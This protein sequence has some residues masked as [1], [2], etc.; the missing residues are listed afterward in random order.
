MYC[1]YSIQIFFLISA[2]NVQALQAKKL[3]ILFVLNRFPA[4]SKSIIVNQMTSLIDAGHNVHIYT[5]KIG[6]LS[7]IDGTVKKYRLFDKK[8]CFFSRPKNLDQ[9]DII[10]V[11]Y[12]NLAEEFVSIKKR[13]SV[14]WKLVVYFRGADITGNK[15]AY[16]EEY[17]MLFE[18]VD[19]CLTVCGYYKYR[20]RKIF[21]CPKEKLRVI[22]STIDCNLFSYY[23]PSLRKEYV[24]LI[25]VGRLIQK[26]GMHYIIRA[27]ANLRE[28]GHRVYL[29]I[30]GEGCYRKTLEKLIKK[31]KLEKF[32]I[33]HGWKNQKVI[34]KY[35]RSSDIFV[36]P[37]ITIANGSQ[38]GI[39]NAL[40]EAM[41]IGRPVIA[42]FHAGTQELVEQGINGFLVPERDVDNLVR[43]ILYLIKWPNL[44]RTMGENGR[45][46]VLKEY[47][48][49]IV[50]K[51]LE[52]VLY[53]LVRT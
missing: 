6:D 1:I 26:K 5:H 47:D 18:Y 40:K 27:V 39:A 20:L 44:R 19:L 43:K 33:L 3:S 36:L 25:S 10:L 8:I 22:P 17:K 23:R 37:S 12:G 35:L 48:M 52:K 51:K 45:K 4:P 38:E 53:N 41:A 49:R 32:V 11:Q 31:L 34:V 30:I 2:Y 46:K 42:T 16:Q 50:N 13:E 29:N 24:R 21:G 14:P 28:K 9:Y 7:C 15:E